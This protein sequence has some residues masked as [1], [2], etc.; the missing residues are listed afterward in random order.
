MELPPLGADQGD[1]SRQDDPPA[2]HPT[3]TEETRS[4]K[5]RTFAGLPRRS[6]PS[7]PVG[8][9][10]GG[11]PPGHRVHPRR[12]LDPAAEPQEPGEPPLA[13]AGI[14]RLPSPIP[15]PPRPCRVHRRC[16]LRAGRRPAGH[17]AIIA[18]VPRSQSNS[19]ARRITPQPSP[20]FFQDWVCPPDRLG[21]KGVSLSGGPARQSRPECRSGP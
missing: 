21:A 7:R 14:P 13:V 10:A 1:V 15:R 20:D 12:H 11:R 18:C 16:P 2:R 17:P 19:L 4:V 5:G 8:S 6:G 3:S 9:G